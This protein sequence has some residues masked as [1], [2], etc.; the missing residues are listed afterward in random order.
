MAAPAHA[1]YVYSTSVGQQ[2]SDV[3]V[4]TVTQID[5]NTVN[6]LVD[7]IDTT[8]PA[9]QYGFLNTGGPHTPFAFTLSG[10]ELGVTGSFLQP[11]GG[12][13]SFGLLSLSTGDGSN[14]PYGTYGVS[15]YSS[16]G[17]G[18]GNAYR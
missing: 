12:N 5:A 8:L 14:T 15:I 16:A 7:L 17:D 18:S 11:S 3:G 1:A 2:P 4:I 13:F 6:V 10:T 9:P